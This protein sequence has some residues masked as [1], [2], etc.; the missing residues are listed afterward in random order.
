MIDKLMIHTLLTSAMAVVVHL[1]APPFGAI[2]S[3]PPAGQGSA[4]EPAFYFAG[5]VMDDDLNPISGARVELLGH[6]QSTLTDVDG[7]YAITFAETAS[8]SYFLLEATAPAFGGSFQ[9][10]YLPQ[11]RRVEIGDMVLEH[12]PVYRAETP[13]GPAVAHRYLRGLPGPGT[14]E[15]PSDYEV[16]PCLRYD[17]SFVLQRRNGWVSKRFAAGPDHDASAD[18]RYAAHVPGGV[19]IDGRVCVT[20]L[21]GVSTSRY[22][23]FDAPPGSGFGHHYLAFEVVLIDDQNQVL[24]NPTFAGLVEVEVREPT[25]E[26][27]PGWFLRLDR[28]AYE[29]RLGARYVVDP[30]A[31]VDWNADAGRYRFRLPHFSTWSGGTGSWNTETVYDRSQAHRRPAPA[32]P[33]AQTPPPRYEPRSEK[34][35]TLEASIDVKCGKPFGWYEVSIQ[36]G[37]SLTWGLAFSGKAELL[38]WWPALALEL[39]LN[40]ELNGTGTRTREIRRGVGGQ[41]QVYDEHFSGKVELWMLKSRAWLVEIAADGSEK[42]VPG[43]RMEVEEGAEVIAVDDGTGQDC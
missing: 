4:F 29:D 14:S 26:L 9:Q 17:F 35:K 20:R 21:P 3:P 24:P 39:G 7:R 43:S 23:P 19:T 16:D 34:T 8:D 13:G 33:P 30:A 32:P 6:G 1:S 10:V 25:L 18:G 41:G 11:T 27:T 2:Q 42:E 36:R 38:A 22:D 5:Q 28:L 12:E 31:A 15:R 37:E 40:A